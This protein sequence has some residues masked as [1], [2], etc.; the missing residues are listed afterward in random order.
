M[1]LIITDAWLA[2]SRAVYLSG[3]RLVVVGF[4]AALALMLVAAG[5][6]HWVF[7]KGAREGWPVIGSLVKLVVKD[8]VEQ[9]D[10]FM[11]E[12]I[13]V[14]AKRLGEMQAKMMQL[15]ALGERVSGLA[16]VNPND[17]KTQPGRGGVLVTGRSLT[18]EE[19]QATLADLDRLTDQ[20]VDLMTV[21]ES[22]LFDQK[23]KK[24][25]VPTQQP[26]QTGI[27]GSSFGWRIDPLNGRSALHTG[28]DFP[29]E[30]GTSILAAAGG[31]VVAQEYHSA[32]GNMVEVDHGNDLV[33]RYAHASRVLV[34]KGD[35]IK[36]GQKIAEV[37]TTGRSTGPHLHFE[38]LVQGV[39]QDPQKFLTAGQKLPQAPTV[40]IAQPTAAQ[41]APMPRPK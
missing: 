36:R 13:D 35:L 26:V 19:L 34:K 40:A 14:M 16:G 25:M 12:N 31:V 4:V 15:E 9:R 10:R 27:L 17:I 2:K 30:P 21:M 8:E 3:T 38:V 6:Y 11:R 24:M 32:Y 23:I 28:L 33:T 39:Y 5:M 29:A 18:M 20:R 7:L 37:G 41:P 1:H 22:R